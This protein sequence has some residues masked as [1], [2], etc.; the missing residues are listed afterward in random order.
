VDVAAGG[1]CRP[2]HV[3]QLVGLVGGLHDFV[4][5]HVDAEEALLQGEVD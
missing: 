3:H 5:G 4:H 2:G 1:R